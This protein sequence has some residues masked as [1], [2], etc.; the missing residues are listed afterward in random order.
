MVFLA[1]WFSV[2]IITMLI[3]YILYD[4]NGSYVLKNINADTSTPQSIIKGKT[5]TQAL[6]HARTHAR[7]HAHTHTHTHIVV[8]TTY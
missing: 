7:T 3:Y 6:T 5:H 1:N 4:N 2:Y 8:N